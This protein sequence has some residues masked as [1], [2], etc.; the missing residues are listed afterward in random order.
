VFDSVQAQSDNE[1]PAL[2][3]PETPVSFEALETGMDI[4]G[5][6]I[7]TDF[8]A[9]YGLEAGGFGVRSVHEAL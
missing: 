8:T 7:G 1:Y 4:E 3:I 2:M 6:R 9:H 5:K